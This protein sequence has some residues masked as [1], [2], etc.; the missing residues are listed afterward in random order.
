M[1]CQT[2]LSV[3]FVHGVQARTVTPCFLYYDFKERG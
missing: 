3:Y 1:K 2:C